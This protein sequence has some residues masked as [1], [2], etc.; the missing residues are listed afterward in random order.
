MD[1]GRVCVKLSG[2]ESGRQCVIIDVID[3]NYVLVT[4][5]EEL[6]GVRRRRVNM[7]HLRPL[8]ERLE[9]SRGASDEEIINLLK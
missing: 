7:N 3:R 2:R 8:E 1:V 9:I 5:P 6:T 4:G